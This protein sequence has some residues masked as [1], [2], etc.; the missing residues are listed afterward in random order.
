MI[1]F[2]YSLKRLLRRSGNI[3]L[4]IVLPALLLLMPDAGEAQWMQLPVAMQLFGLGLW[5][6]AARLSVLV[7]EDRSNRV[8]LR[9]AVAPIRYRTYLWQVLLSFLILLTAVNLVVIGGTSLRYGVDLGPSAALFAL[10]TLFAMAAT[11]F[12]LAWYSLVRDRET[13]S[14]V[15]VVLIILLTMLGGMMW[16]IQ[17]MPTW[18]QY[19]ARILPTYWM[20]EGLLAIGHGAPWTQLLLPM[21]MLL[22]MSLLFLLAGSSKRIA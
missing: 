5:F 7:L 1:V 8:L 3:I 17:I 10:H 9:V 13:A 21:G 12:L 14:I 2:I 11:T 15:A 20:A 6:I 16:P 22:A 19:L 18:L 4:L